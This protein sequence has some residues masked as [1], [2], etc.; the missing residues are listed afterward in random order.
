MPELASRAL[1]RVEYDD[2]TSVL[3]VWFAESGEAW[4]H[5]A[6]PRAVYQALLAAEAPGRYFAVDIR[7][8]YPARRRSRSSDVASALRASL[9]STT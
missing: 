7:E 2:A 3:T 5:Y 4:D 8:R 1:A 9:A 6:V